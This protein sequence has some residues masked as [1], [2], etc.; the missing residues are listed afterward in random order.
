MTGRKE[1]DHEQNTAQKRAITR[2]LATKNPRMLA[3]MSMICVN[4][5]GFPC[6]PAMYACPTVCKA[7]MSPADTFTAA[8]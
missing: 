6:L 3:A 2:H 1:H 8:G 4:I 7:C 5:G